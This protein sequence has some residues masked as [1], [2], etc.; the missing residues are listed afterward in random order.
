VARATA[1]PRPG[2]FEIHSVPIFMLSRGDKVELVVCKARMV[3][4]TGRPTTSGERR[5]VDVKV[6]DWVATGK[7]RLLGGKVEF[8]MTQGG[9][10]P[11]SWVKAGTAGDL[12]GK[13]RFAMRYSVTTPQGTLENLTGAATGAISSFPPKLDVFRIDKTLNLGDLVLGGVA[14]A[15][16]GPEDVL[17]SLP[18]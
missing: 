2:K 18:G 16:P 17:I 9:R 4:E 5:Q 11:R 15:C 13:A 6:L 7:S 1:F 8:R 10:Q 12:P 3:V 14:C